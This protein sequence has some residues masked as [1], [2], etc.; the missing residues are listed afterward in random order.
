ME[1]TDPVYYRIRSLAHC[2]TNISYW[3]P[4]RCM[5]NNPQSFF[6]QQYHHLSTKKK[7][8]GK[9]TI[10][11]ITDINVPKRYNKLFLYFS[12]LPTHIRLCCNSK[13]V[14]SCTLSVLM[15]YSLS[16]NENCSFSYIFF[17]GRKMMILLYEEGL[18]VVIHTSNLVEKDWYQKT[19][20]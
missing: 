18:R 6:I 9:R 20:G 3:L 10:F 15:K 5:Y 14:I 19:Q 16:N 11:I 8:I 2:V 4:L 13:I 7:D 17:F 1:F 12:K